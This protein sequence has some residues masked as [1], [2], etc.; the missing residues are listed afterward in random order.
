MN[1]AASLAK[2][3]GLQAVAWAITPFL[4]TKYEMREGPLDNGNGYGEGPRLPEKYA[5]FDTPD[6]SLMGDPRWRAT[7]HDGA[8]WIDRTKWLYRNSLY[9]YKTTA[10]AVDADPAKITHEGNPAVNRNNG[11]TGTFRARSEDGH[12]QYKRVQKLIGD[13]GLMWNFGWQLDEAV[14]HGRPT[15]AQFQFSPRFVRIK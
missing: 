14:S 7:G 4:A 3:L 10:L 8:R 6:N 11:I 1:Y 5:I 13:W 15:K 9:G 2:L 12:W